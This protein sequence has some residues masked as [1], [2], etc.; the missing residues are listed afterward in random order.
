MKKSMLAIIVVVLVILSSLLWILN[1]ET[2]VM[3]EGLQF[4]I[5]AALVVF[6]LFFAYRRLTSEKRGEPVEDEFSK[7]VVQ[8]AAAFSY[9]V[10][11]YL[12]LVI[13]YLT[14]KLKPETDIMFGWGILGMAVV[15]AL[16][17]LY[18]NF[19]GIRNE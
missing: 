6:G 14:D 10:S 9:Y 1:A 17:W 4:L 3:G 15:F 11:I 16:S 18:F 7:K 8:K 12:W 19:R 2:L 5:I 13:M